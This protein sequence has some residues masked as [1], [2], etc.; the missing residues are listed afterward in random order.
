VPRSLGVVVPLPVGLVEAEVSGDSAGSRE[1]CPYNC[2]VA[3]VFHVK[4]FCHEKG[5]NF[6]LDKHLGAPV[7]RSGLF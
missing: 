7:G 6:L 5:L 4:Q 3:T 1:V 2:T